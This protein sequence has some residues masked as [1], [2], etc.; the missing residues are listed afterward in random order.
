[1]S[2][3]TGGPGLVTNGLVLY[4]DA[5][6]PSSY[7]SGSLNWNDLSRSSLSGS[8]VNGPTFNTGS[9]GSIVFD[10]INDTVSIPYT[11]TLD[12]T[13]VTHQIQSILEHNYNV[14]MDTDWQQT[15]H[16]D[17]ASVLIKY[18]YLKDHSK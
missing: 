8:L 10:G 6:N 4:L 14:M 7:I 5:A 16:K 3:L 2:T 11:T 1:M 13:E 9:G 15:M 17:I 18:R 12:P